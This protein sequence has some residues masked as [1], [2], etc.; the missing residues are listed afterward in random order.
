M[1]IAAT[2]DYYFRK[3]LHSTKHAAIKAQTH[4]RY[5]FFNRFQNFRNEN[6][7]IFYNLFLPFFLLTQKK[8]S[9][10]RVPPPIYR[11]EAKLYARLQN[12]VLNYRRISLIVPKQTQSTLFAK[13]LYLFFCL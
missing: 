4:F 3:V 8:W 1:I 11:L 7:W 5:L 6:I 12:I 9:K 2:A 13:I 10:K